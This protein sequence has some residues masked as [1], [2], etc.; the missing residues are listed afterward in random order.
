MTINT[1]KSSQVEDLS[2]SNLTSEELFSAVNGDFEA[3]SFIA[4][5]RALR[6]EYRSAIELIELG[7]FAG[8]VIQVLQMY[9]PQ[10]IA[11]AHRAEFSFFRKRYLADPS[12]W[13]AHRNKQISLLKSFKDHTEVDRLYSDEIIERTLT[14]E[15]YGS[16]IPNNAPHHV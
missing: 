9:A 7:A 5:N 8:T 4:K 12:A 16:N 1:E 10:L 3:I 13:E 6:F 11:N 2:E 14:E 15:G